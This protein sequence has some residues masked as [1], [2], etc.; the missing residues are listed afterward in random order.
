MPPSEQQVNEPSGSPPPVEP[1]RTPRIP[2]LEDFPD[3]GPN[4]L[5]ALNQ[6]AWARLIDAV[7]VSV[8]FFFLLYL[9]I[10]P[11]TG[12]DLQPTAR[13]E[14]LT[15]QLQPLVAIGALVGGVLYETIAVAWLGKTVGKT[16]LGLRVARYA[17]GEK[18]EWG[19]AALR[20]LLPAAGGAVTYALVQISTLG[21][22]IVLG[23]AYFLPLRRGWQDL[24]G[25]TIVIRTR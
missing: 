22:V 9:L 16:L 17:D 7:L 24:A 3:H 25:G 20:A 4:A 11:T 21:L 13:T 1:V 23:S 15:A 6:R 19:Q 18:P 5:G 14:E 2:T 10:V 8:P 12:T